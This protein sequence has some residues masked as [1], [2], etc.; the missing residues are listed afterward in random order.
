[1]IRRMRWSGFLKLKSALARSTEARSAR[2]EGPPPISFESASVRIEKADADVARAVFAE[3][4]RQL[5]FEHGIR[6]KIERKAHVTLSVAGLAITLAGGLGLKLVT[7]PESVVPMPTWAYTTLCV[8]FLLAIVLG[9]IASLLALLGLRVAGDTQQADY[10]D[11]FAEPALVNEVV[12][13]RWMAVHL[14]SVAES[15]HIKNTRR[16]AYVRWA[17]R[18]FFAFLCVL[19]GLCFLVGAFVV[20]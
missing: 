6:D 5:E 1:M 4:R 14:F 19:A 18:S 8:G 7:E 15:Q 9:L 16:A 11:V 20:F 12:W 2:L 17:L 3:C 13:H 10:R